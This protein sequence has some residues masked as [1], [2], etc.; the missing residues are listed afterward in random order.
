M[1]CLTLFDLPNR[2]SS[3]GWPLPSTS[4]PLCLSPLISWCGEAWWLLKRSHSTPPSW[5]SCTSPSTTSTP[6]GH[7]L[8]H[9]RQRPPSPSPSLPCRLH[10]LHHHQVHLPPLPLLL[11]LLLHLLHPMLV[12]HH[13]FLLV[14][15]KG[16]SV[17]WIYCLACCISCVFYLLY[18]PLSPSFW[19][20]HTDIL[21]TQKGRERREKEEEK[22]WNKGVTW[23]K[24]SK[25]LQSET[26]KKNEEIRSTKNRLAYRRRKKI[27]GCDERKKEKKN[28]YRRRRRRMQEGRN[29]EEINWRN[30]EGGREWGA[31]QRMW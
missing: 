17:R 8:S 14:R 22:R 15:C 19:S 4:W 26:R 21:H 5:N 7:T 1:T 16:R 10:P 2:S 31:R 18:L 9:T 24:K 27:K 28:M 6:P 20:S 11:L 25:R 3:Q 13:L 23:H 12:C 29:N 30:N